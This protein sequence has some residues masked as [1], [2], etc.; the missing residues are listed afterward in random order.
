[1][2]AHIRWR[3][4]FVLMI[5]TPLVLLAQ[6]SGE[7]AG[8]WSLTSDASSD[9]PSTLELKLQGAKIT[10]TLAGPS[11]T[12]E[13]AGEYKDGV[14]TFALDY[15]EQVRVVFTGTLEADDSLKGTMDYGQGP[16]A[17]RAVRIKGT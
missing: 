2:I 13:I 3:L 11:G 17:W 1:M 12:F 14:V 6:A 9:G 7:L 4:T 5:L 10:G 8:K 16:V 15:S